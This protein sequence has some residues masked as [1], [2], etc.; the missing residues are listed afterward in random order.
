MSV[1]AAQSVFINRLLVTV[2]KRLP[3]LDR[4]KIIATGATDLQLV[5]SSEELP[6]IRASYLDGLHGAWAM[7]I[8]FACVALLTGLTLGF[9]SA[10][11][12]DGQDEKN[13]EKVEKTV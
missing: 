6:V 8:A 7:A 10:K 12:P 2:A 13:V 5:F 1:A 4:I 9:K 3:D 11:K